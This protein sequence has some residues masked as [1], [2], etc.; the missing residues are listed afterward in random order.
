MADLITF[1]NEGGT[2]EILTQKFQS[3]EQPI[4]D[5]FPTIVYSAAW[6]EINQYKMSLR[7]P[8]VLFIDATCKTNVPGRPLVYVC[9]QDNEKKSGRR[10]SSGDWGGLFFLNFSMEAVI[11][12]HCLFL[13]LFL[14]HCLV[15]CPSSG[16]CPVYL[17][18]ALEGLCRQSP[19]K[20]ALHLLRDCLWFVL[21]LFVPSKPVL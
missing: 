16:H 8:E 2:L 19:S 14:G 21:G 10:S 20:P 4:G 13:F 11:G 3:D 17:R 15:P 7:F 18:I 9:L 5:Q 6:V 12:L 1:F